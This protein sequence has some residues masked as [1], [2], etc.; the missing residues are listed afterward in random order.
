MTDQARVS[1]LTTGLVTADTG[2]DPVVALGGAV[3][4]ADDLKKIHQSTN[5]V[6][7]MRVVTKYRVK[8]DSPESWGRLWQTRLLRGTVGC[9]WIRIGG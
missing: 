3:P 7:L 6:N 2:G 1:N 8:A 9:E 4:L 5:S